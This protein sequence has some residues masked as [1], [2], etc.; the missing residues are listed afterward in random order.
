MRDANTSC[1]NTISIFMYFNI[2][3]WFFLQCDNNLHWINL[4]HI[5]GFD[6]IYSFVLGHTKLNYGVNIFHFQCGRCQF[7]NNNMWWTIQELCATTLLLIRY[8]RALLLCWCH[9]SFHSFSAF[10]HHSSIYG[11]CLLRL[12]IYYFADVIVCLLVCII[13][14]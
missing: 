5:M 13:H 11:A 10:W 14:K 9:F 7:P 8:V 1:N 3:K 2:R 6:S 12:L 4:Y